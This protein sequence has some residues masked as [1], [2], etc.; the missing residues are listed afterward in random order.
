M[1]PG[2]VKIIGSRPKFTSY[3]TD[4]IG[5]KIAYLREFGFADSVQMIK[6]LQRS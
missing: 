4:T 2:D 1:A 3:T 6:S 5:R